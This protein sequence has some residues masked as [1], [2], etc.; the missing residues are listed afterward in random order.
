M[1]DT[2]EHVMTRVLPEVPVRQWVLSLP[3]QLRFQVAFDADLFGAI[4]R[5]F[6]DEVFRDHATRA[7]TLGVRDPRSG[8]IA[9]VQRFGS[10]LN[11]NPHLHLITVDGVY[12]REEGSAEA[13]LR[14]HPL[15]SP[16]VREVE[17]VSAATCRR[18][19]QLLR[20]RGLATDDGLIPRDDLDDHQGLAE[21]ATGQPPLLARVES[22]GRVQRVRPETRP[23]RAGEVRGFSVHAGVFASAGETQR[24]RRIVRYCLRPP[25]AASQF[26]ATRD[27][28]VAFSLRHP[29]ADGATHVVF[30]ELTVLH[31]LS[32]LV[33]PPGRH[34][35]KY[36]GVLAS[37]SPL[38]QEVVPPPPIDLGLA[39][40]EI[41]SAADVPAARISAPGRRASWAQLLR[42]VYDIEALRCPRCRG[43]LKFIAAITAGKATRAILDHLDLNDEPPP[44]RRSQAPPELFHP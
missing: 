29:R 4:V 21:L 17:Q 30:P 12:A 27:G 44:A 11:L 13:P 42:R 6:V 16:S 7:R 35:V 33:P 9:C 19:L 20:R 1:E 2:T 38:R 32:A 28:R 22:N 37:A 15:P 24:R 18:V 10:T 5:I 40:S 26:T 34:A 43:P 3:F 36:F 41:L 14:F 8:A 23:P 25:F 31:K 39:S